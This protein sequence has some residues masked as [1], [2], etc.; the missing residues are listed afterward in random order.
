MGIDKKHELGSKAVLVLATTFV[1]LLGLAGCVVVIVIASPQAG[2][3]LLILA[4][5]VLGMGALLWLVRDRAPNASE[6]STHWRF[7]RRRPPKREYV[8]K[9]LKPLPEGGGHG[10]PT[11]E[12][13]RELADGSLNTW[14][15]SGLNSQRGAPR[16]PRNDE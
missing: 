14:V 2:R 10:P 1:V 3:D 9:R 12:S 11:A 4:G 13:L 6:P 8:V 5:C 16:A 7:W 15:P